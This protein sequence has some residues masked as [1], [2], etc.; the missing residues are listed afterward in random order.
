V[1]RRNLGILVLLLAFAAPAESPVDP[2]DVAALDT[3]PNFVLI[4]TDDQRWDTIGRCEP[5]LDGFTLSAGAASCMPNLQQD[6]MSRGVTF[7]RGYVTTALCCPS[8][9]SILTGRYARHTGVMHNEDYDQFDES[10]TVA[11][12]LSAAGYRTGFVGKYLNGYGLAPT[13]ANHVPAGWDT[14]HAFWE[15]AIDSYYTKYDLLEK[16]PGTPTT[17][18]RYQLPGKQTITGACA[19]GNVYSTDL[20]CRRALEFIGSAGDT[21]FLLLLATRSPHMS[22]I[23]A[24][25]HRAL[26]KSI[27]FPSYPNRNVVPGPGTWIRKNP[28]TADR[29]AKLE[30]QWRAML[31]THRAVDDAIH[32]LY[33]Q[34]AADGRLA[35]TVWL[36]VSD[37]SIGRGEHRWE[38][39]RCEYEECHRIPFVAVCPAAVCPSP[40]AGVVDADHLVLNIDLA[41]TVADLA[42]VAPVPEPDGA[43]L[44]PLL[45]A[46][47]ST[48]RDG[49]VIENWDKPAPKT[50]G[51]VGIAG[52][53]HLYKY[54]EVQSPFVSTELFD[55]T[56]DP[57][58]LVNRAEDP[59]YQAVRNEMDAR[60]DAALA[61]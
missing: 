57:W 23:P 47:A 12:W 10:S 42:G 21:P 3:R 29:L 55:L 20:L 24:K 11:T 50:T 58:E 37:N 31:R 41:A 4:V 5:T 19:A 39:K 8:R 36:F 30:T 38:D 6:L 61:A 33:A 40:R 52:D 46:S 44:R 9:S 43:S 51:F 25:R 28:L 18:K 2:P 45:G 60:L 27:G 7:Q 32:H 26:Y 49:F 35:R 15:G 48:W 13:P 53:G 1:R 22:A 14:W 59:A 16:T 17:K 54:V 56:A 34:L